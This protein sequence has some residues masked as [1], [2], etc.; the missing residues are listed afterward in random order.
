[1]VKRKKRTICIIFTICIVISLLPAIKTE[2]RITET[3]VKAESVKPRLYT[4]SRG[5]VEYNVPLYEPPKP[6]IEKDYILTWADEEN[7]SVRITNEDF[8]LLC[9]TVFCEAGN[10][11]E[12]AQTKV[13]RVILF[14]MIDDRFPNTV[15]EVVYQ[16]NG[17]QFNVVRWNGFPDAYP[18]PDKTEIACFKAICEY[19]EQ[20]F[21]MLAFRS[22]YFFSWGV[23]MEHKPEDGDMFFTR[24][25]KDYTNNAYK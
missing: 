3:V 19:P 7:L 14:R 8:K 25:P 1:M 4:T 15:K 17:T 21:D 5:A 13:A 11:S 6:H 2:D 16:G 23:S 12:E 22:G 20:P 24:L 18:Y 10:Q 9:H